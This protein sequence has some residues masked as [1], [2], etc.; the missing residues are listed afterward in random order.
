MCQIAKRMNEPTST[1][2]AILKRRKKETDIAI[3][4]LELYWQLVQ[5]RLEREGVMGKPVLST[6]RYKRLR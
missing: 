4:E 6:S 3:K 5:K 2:L 1:K